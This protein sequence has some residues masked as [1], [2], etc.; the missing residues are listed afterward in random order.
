MVF[1]RRFVTVH[2]GDTEGTENSLRFLRVSVVK[3][4]ARQPECPRL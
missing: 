3:P 4:N 2:H 1:E